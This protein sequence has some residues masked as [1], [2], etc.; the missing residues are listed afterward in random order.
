MVT[1]LGRESTDYTDFTDLKKYDPQ[2]GQIKE[3]NFLL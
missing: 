2:I 3:G 1:S